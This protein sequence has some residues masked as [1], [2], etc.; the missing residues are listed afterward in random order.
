VPDPTPPPRPQ[1]HLPA[2][3]TRFVGR[4]REL[5]ELQGL[6]QARRLVCVTGPPG[7]GK[8]RLAVEVAASLLEAFP[9]GVWFV[10]L[11]EAADPE[12]VRSAV[13][14]AL[15]VPE[16]PE[17]P[18]AQALTDHLR[19]RRLLL[20]PDNFEHVL[21]AAVVAAQL[22]DAAPELRVLA[23]SRTPLR[24]SGEQEY[25]LAPLPLPRPEERAAARLWLFPLEE[26]ARR[27]SPAV[28][29]LTGGAGRPRRPAADPAGRDRLERPAARP[30]RPRAVAAPGGLPGRL[31]P[32]GR[33]GGRPGPT[34]D[35][36]RGRH[37]HSGRGE[38]AGAAGGARPGA[39]LDAGDDPRVRPG[40]AAGGRGGRCDRRPP[41]P[42][43]RGTVGL[44]GLCYWQGD[45]DA[46]EVAYGHARE[47]AKGLE[48]WWLELEALFG[49]AFT[50]ACQ[51]RECL[52]VAV[53]LGDLAGVALD[54]DRLGQAA[55]ALGQPERAV[56]LAAAADRLRE[57][58][59][60]GLTVESGRWE[61]EHPRAAARR[62]LT[63]SEIDR[64][65]GQGRAMG[66]E[67]AVVFARGW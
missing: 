37:H 28:P 47:L 2:Q 15:G 7:S 21:P 14:T 51:L 1:H 66:L 49:V 67:D 33:R 63:D 61:T 44:G 26:L 52:E 46:A 13:A 9:H 34:R 27:L 32:G 35:R 23:T 53:E 65:W 4:R 48:G 19:S 41:R 25:P 38:P 16:L 5:A 6:L 60:A 22:L 58:V 10:S 45:W 64:A 62:Q 59:G 55:V 8:T 54:L 56:V 20:V 31:H 43:L 42:L 3:R 36:P 18:A 11:A 40:A 57:S 29:L 39:L 12:L 17:R 30:R 24:L 50:L